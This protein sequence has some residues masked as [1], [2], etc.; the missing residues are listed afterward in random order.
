MSEQGNKTRVF[1]GAEARDQLLDGMKK[2]ADA[3]GSTLGPQGRCV[4][5]ASESGPPHVTKDGVTVCR[6]IRLRHPLESLGAEMIKEA[7]SK[8]NDATGDGTTT[9]TVLT[10]SMCYYGRQLIVAGHRPAALCHGIDAGVAAILAELATI[11]KPVSDSDLIDVATIS[12]N[13]ERNIG[14][15]ISDAISAVGRDG[16]VTVE[17]SKSSATTLDVV[18]GMRIDRGYASPYFINDSDRGKCI[19][20]DAYVLV[21]DENLTSIEDIIPLLN[22]IHKA[23]KALLVIASGISPEVMQLFV[24]NKL[25]ND[26][27]VCATEMPGYDFGTQ[28]I[29]A[30]QDICAVVGAKFMH[31]GSGELASSTIEDLGTCSS[32]IIDSKSTTLISGRDDADMKAR[33]AV[34][35][36]QLEDPT[37]EDSKA[38]MLHDRLAKLTGAAAVLRVG[39]AT[40]IEIRERKDRVDDALGATRAAIAYGIVP[41]GATALARASRVLDN[42]HDPGCEIVRKACLSPLETI[43]INSDRSPGVV[44]DKVLSSDVGMGY[45]AAKDEYAN[46]IERGIIDPAMVER[47]ALENAASVAKA[48]ITLNSAIVDE[49]TI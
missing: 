6:A 35:T 39:G 41:G 21:T 45:D 9:A 38:R 29:E 31:K 8:T 24:L 12:A 33:A 27:K 42:R 17:D 28:R 25:R 16:I 11:A 7:A 40:E 32:I 20:T 5:I 34:V 37:L 44:V 22:G 2:V 4:V 19:L 1:F 18:K 14:K 23:G 43:A 47:V 49:E 36:E 30:M 46:L 26:L 3:A 13:G 15:L 48:F 10:H